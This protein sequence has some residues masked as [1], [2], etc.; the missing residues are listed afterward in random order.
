MIKLFAD[1]ACNLHVAE[2]KKYNINIVPLAYSID[3]VEQEYDLEHDFDGKAFYDAMR[4]GAVMKTSMANIDLFIKAFLP[5][6]K[7]GDEIIYIAIAGGISGTYHAASLAKEELLEDYPNAKI[8]VI[9]SLAAGLGVGIQVLDA[10]KHIEKED[11]FESV[12]ERI[13]LRKRH[14]CQYFTVDDLKY[15]KNGGRVSGATA[16]IATILNIKP[17]LIGSDDD[18]G[19]I[20]SVGKCRGM[21]K[22]LDAI[23]EK[24]NELVL[25]KSE[26]VMMIHGDFPKAI[27]YLEK[28]LRERGFTGNITVNYFEPVCA[29][30]V[31]PGSVALFFYGIHK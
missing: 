13:E 24:Y 11:S 22:T 31:G 21:T 29:S 4:N 3:G 18:E 8:A 16:A 23:L 9:N 12:V 10:A 19:H 27:E 20:I 6:V 1:T 26:D 2:I 30:H 7:A 17:I 28:G 14:V 15:L 5:S 25:D